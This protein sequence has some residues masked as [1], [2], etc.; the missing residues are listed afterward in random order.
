MLLPSLTIHTIVKYS[1]LWVKKQGIQS[2]RVRQ[3]LPSALG[4]VLSG[5]S[6][7]LKND[8]FPRAVSA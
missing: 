6:L 3:W 4:C 1:A 8:R 5:L 7:A 2:I